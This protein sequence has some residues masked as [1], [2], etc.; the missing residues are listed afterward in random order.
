MNRY[1]FVS[2]IYI[3]ESGQH[4]GRDWWKVYNE[5]FIAADFEKFT[6]RDYNAYK[7]ITISYQEITDG[8]YNENKWS[9]ETR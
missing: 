4:F 1:F 6:A 5:P 8:E 3:T 2:F 9:N 7:V